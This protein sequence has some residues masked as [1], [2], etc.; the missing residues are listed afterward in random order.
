MEKVHQPDDRSK[1]AE[2][3][4]DISQQTKAPKLFSALSAILD[5]YSPLEA[6]LYQVDNH[7]KEQTQNTQDPY[8][9]STP[10][11]NDKKSSPKHDEEAI[12]WTTP[13]GNSE[14]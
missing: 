5:G 9:M 14:F 1:V 10:T 3:Q 8:N 2:I 4:F 11:V 12:K 13:S 7:S 6:Q